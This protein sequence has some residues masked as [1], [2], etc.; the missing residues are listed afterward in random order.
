MIKWSGGP[1]Y[2]ANTEGQPRP[3]AQALARREDGGLRN[4]VSTKA[5]NNQQPSPISQ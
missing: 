2:L 3:A 5:T 1:F 4:Q